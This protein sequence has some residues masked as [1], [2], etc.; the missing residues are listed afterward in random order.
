MPEPQLDIAIL[1]G[2]PEISGGTNVIMEHALGL[3]RREHRVSIVTQERFDPARL[4]W[5]PGAADLPLLCH[6]DCAGREFDLSVATWW[7]SVFDL[8]YVPARRYVYF[9]QSIESRFFSEREPDMKALAE[10]T[11]RQPLPVV[12]EASWIA[13]YLRENYGRRVTVVQNGIDKRCFSADGSAE[14]DRPSEGLRV[15]VE[16]PLGVPFKR[17]EQ[18]IDLCRRAA[19]GEVWLLT[20]SACESYEGVDRVFSRAP[21]NL[22][23]RIYRSCDVLVKLSTVEGM[24]GPPLEMM[25]C[26]GTAITTDVTGHEEYMRHRENG[27]VVPR[28]REE[29]VVGHLRRL[30]SDRGLLERLREGGLRTARSWP[31]WDDSTAGME[32]FV[33]AVAGEPVSEEAVH[34]QM[35]EHLRAAL[36][37]AGPLHDVVHREQSGRVLL[38]QL[39]EKVRVRVVKKMPVLAPLLAGEGN[40]SNG[41]ANGLS[42]GADR[43]AGAMTPLPAGASVGLLEP[44][45]RYRVCFVGDARAHWHLVPQSSERI[46]SCFVPCGRAIG[47]AEAEAVELFSPDVTVVFEPERHREG[48]IARLGGRLIGYCIGE[49]S[50]GA[51]GVLRSAFPRTEGPRGRVVVHADA[52][53]VPRL[54][55]AGVEAVA[56]CPVPAGVEDEPCWH[57]YEQWR[58]RGL[59]VA[60]FGGRTRE[61]SVLHSVPGVRRIEP[62]MPEALQRALLASSR[63]VVIP[64]GRGCASGAMAAAAMLSGCLVVSNRLPDCYGF[65]AGEHFLHYRDDADLRGVVE[66]T[67]RLPDDRDVIRRVGMARAAGHSASR[68]YPSIIEQYLFGAARSGRQDEGA[69]V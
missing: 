49:L 25:H 8:P 28:G 54:L 67:V 62:D 22:V 66:R 45:E 47:R 7:R 38:R 31:S 4:S 17:V 60:V 37:L 46:E 53:Q 3:T 15:L 6:A 24:F 55:S 26:G 50:G 19:V 34:Y 43:A 36:R 27:L 61:G 39:G 35:T 64:G 41:A 69:T 23:G 51:V 56:G 1:L 42:G 63:V 2:Y 10:Y 18:T 58:H 32:R 57:P 9:C 59:A 29:D 40:A 21:I 68:V 44:R 65:M 13:R 48:S 11:Y 5:K 30:A 52:G 16:G 33:R 20:S 14:A 12:T